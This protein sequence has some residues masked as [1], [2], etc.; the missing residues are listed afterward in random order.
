MLL[1]LKWT[2]FYSLF[3]PWTWSLVWP[4]K[5]CT[6]LDPE[7]VHWFVAGTGPLLWRLNW[8]TGLAP[9]LGHWVGP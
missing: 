4:L 3:G 8:C 9:G 5:W 2:F 6:C 7:L 1:N